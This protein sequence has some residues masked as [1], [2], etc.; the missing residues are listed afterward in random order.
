M[1]IS[2]SCGPDRHICRG[3]DFSVMPDLPK[4]GT[5]EANQS[6]IMDH[7]TRTTARN[8][9]DFV[10]QLI[11]Q[12]RL[13]SANYKQKVMLLPHGGDF[14]YSKAVNWDR[15]YRNMKLFMK[16]INERES[17]FNIKIKFGTF[18]DYFEE[19]NRQKA[20]HNLKFPVISGDFFT[21][22][23]SDD[24]W[25]GYFTT[26]QFDKRLSREV[27]E[28]LRAAELFAAISFA[29]GKNGI[30]IPENKKKKILENLV[31]ARQNLGI[32]Q[33]HDAITGTARAHVVRD[34]EERLSSAFTATQDVMTTAL[35]HILQKDRATLR[36]DSVLPTLL[37]RGYNQLTD[38]VPVPATAAG[39]KVFL[40]NSLLQARKETVSLMVES[41]EVI[42]MDH[43]GLEV[44]FDTIRHMKGAAEII[45]NVNFP[46]LS[47]L[48]YTLKE[49]VQSDSKR[50][51]M[52]IPSDTHE[53][54][55]CENDQVNITFSTETASPSQI[56]YKSK[57]VCSR[58]EIDW[59]YYMGRGGAY[60][61]ISNGKQVPA[62][63]SKPKITTTKG[64]RFCRVELDYNYFK[65]TFTLDLS[66]SITG[67][68]LRVNIYSDLTKYPHFNGDLAMRVITK[69]N[70]NGT[71]YADSNGIQLMGRKFRKSIP[72]DGNVYPMT[73]VA[74]MED[75]NHRV[76]VHSA[77]PHGVV[78][79]TSGV[80]DFMIDRVGLRSEM[81]MPE[82][83]ADNKPTKTILFIEFQTPDEY[84]IVSTQETAL[85]PI[86]SVYL[87][88]ILQHPIFHFYSIDDLT[89]S[90]TLHSF[91]RQEISC[92]IILANVKNLASDDLVP[93]GL[94][95]TFHRR[96]ISC[97]KNVNEQVCHI[98]EKTLI[99]PSAFFQDFSAR[100]V[101]HMALSHL[102]TQKNVYGSEEARLK[103][104]DFETFHVQ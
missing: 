50:P 64:Q 91:L 5:A 76:L 46:P 29:R 57:D 9:D 44:E 82:G 31:F 83:A 65:A 23:E 1:S 86:N 66:S 54:I 60:T 24:Y 16:Y 3:I 32:F 100:S 38:R 77:Q 49:K 4:P 51:V 39:I 99:N 18:K 89:I 101:H 103:P 22:T 33:H 21:Y 13:K 102:M 62:Y 104:M 52:V 95:L 72:F 43:K 6:F 96:G 37:R 34:Y 11:R 85:L 67:R 74:M 70:N 58:F 19:L 93:D 71:F 90:K 81:G 73:S 14:H 42:L 98:S 35:D 80:L 17:E 55:V 88:D 45:F 61:M 28:S 78:S 27:Q 40:V 59:R 94:S 92:D 48:V 56:C 10:R 97:P 79:P 47:I 75:S 20:A 15:Q 2:D 84:E 26:R 63:S 36:Y 8:L 69:I 87:N 12:F 68:S 7:M 53:T 41:P 30:P 25:T